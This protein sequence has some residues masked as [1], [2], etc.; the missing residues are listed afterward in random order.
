M[1]ARSANQP[2]N[3]AAKSPPPGAYDLPEFGNEC[4]VFSRE[5]LRSAMIID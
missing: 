1:D 3:I 2:I 5:R 4:H